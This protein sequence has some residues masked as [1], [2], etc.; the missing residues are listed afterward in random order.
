M[1]SITKTRLLGLLA[2][3][4]LSIQSGNSLAES[5]KPAAKDAS[6]DQLECRTLLRLSGDERAYTLLYLHGY[7]SGKLGQLHLDVQTMAEVTDRVVDHC[8]DHPSDKLLPVFQKQ[9]MAR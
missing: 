7:V 5:D 3:A 4:A 9:R 6:L 2:M 1:I 8:I